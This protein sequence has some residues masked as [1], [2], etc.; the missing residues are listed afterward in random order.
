MAAGCMRQE[1]GCVG[2]V[3]H[4]NNLHPRPSMLTNN[5]F[6]STETRPSARSDLRIQAV[7]LECLLNISRLWWEHKLKNTELLKSW[8]LPLKYYMNIGFYLYFI[9]PESISQNLRCSEH[10]PGLCV[11]CMFFMFHKWF[12]QNL[13]ACQTNT[14][15]KYELLAAEVTEPNVT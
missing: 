13:I 4:K 5:V 15:L 6:S 9:Q 10:V 11:F 12:C 8:I 7:S 3:L 1:V 2:E 14:Q